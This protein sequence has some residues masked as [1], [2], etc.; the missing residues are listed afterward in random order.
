MIS[1][2]STVSFGMRLFTDGITAARLAATAADA[3][4]RETSRVR[5]GAYSLR[6]MA[7]SMAIRSAC[8]AASRER[9]EV[10]ESFI[11]VPAFGA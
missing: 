9:W 2:S 5:I 6:A 3:L 8:S 4:A 10:S 1:R 11:V 7:F